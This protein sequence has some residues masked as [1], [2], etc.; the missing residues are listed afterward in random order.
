MLD[1]RREPLHPVPPI[2]FNYSCSLW[3]KIGTAARGADKGLGGKWVLL[4]QLDYSLSSG[5]KDSPSDLEREQ[6]LSLLAAVS[7]LALGLSSL[8]GLSFGFCFI[9]SGHFPRGNLGPSW[10]WWVQYK[11]LT[12]TPLQEGRHKSYEVTSSNSSLT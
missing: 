2:S 6:L 8:H 7:S 5:R 9:L 12:Q 4:A 1:Y 10:H 11:P 3:E